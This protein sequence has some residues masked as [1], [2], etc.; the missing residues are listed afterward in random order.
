MV[1]TCDSMSITTTTTAP[2]VSPHFCHSCG[3]GENT[4]LLQLMVPLLHQFV[5]PA[6][7]RSVLRGS[8][9]DW[10]HNW[11]WFVDP[12]SQFETMFWLQPCLFSQVAPTRFFLSLRGKWFTISE[13]YGSSACGSCWASLTPL[14]SRH[15]FSE[16][17]TRTLTPGEQTQASEWQQ[18]VT[19]RL[20]RSCWQTTPELVE[21]FQECSA[22]SASPV[23]PFRTRVILILTWYSIWYAYSNI[24]Q[25]S[26]LRF[27]QQW[28]KTHLKIYCLFLF[29]KRIWL[30]SSEQKYL[31]VSGVWMFEV[32]K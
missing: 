2:S 26:W 8:L 32:A 21:C 3:A 10:H 9:E 14:S 31:V 13:V 29:L 20:F 28:G 6:D 15:Q 24:S 12:L 1:R 11:S 22:P 5:L 23:P 19:A 4:S 27:S 16:P 25:V 17:S 7:D 30:Y 18:E